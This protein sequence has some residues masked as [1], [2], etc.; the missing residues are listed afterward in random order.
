MSEMTRTF[1]AG[2][3]TASVA[4]RTFPASIVCRV[5]PSTTSG[6]A[7]QDHVYT[8]S[9]TTMRWHAGNPVATY[10]SET[11][12]P[13]WV[14]SCLENDTSEVDAMGAIT[15]PWN[16]WEVSGVAGAKVFA[17]DAAA[18][19]LYMFSQTVDAAEFLRMLARVV[20]WM[21]DF[22]N[23]FQLRDFTLQDIFYT[24]DARGTFTHHLPFASGVDAPRHVKP[25]TSPT[26]APGSA[27]HGTLEWTIAACIFESQNVPVPEMRKALWT[28]LGTN[29]EALWASARVELGKSQMNPGLRALALRFADAA[30][31]NE[32]I[33]VAAAL[34]ARAASVRSS[35]RLLMSADG[36]VGAVLGYI[37][38]TNRNVRVHE[39][40]RDPGTHR[41]ISS[42]TKSD[43]LEH[44]REVDS[45]EQYYVGVKGAKR[46]YDDILRTPPIWTDLDVM[47]AMVQ[48]W[49]AT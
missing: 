10:V 2:Q 15:L 13:I 25:F 19:D 22:E 48:S 11:N 47:D 27:S 7:P 8:L 21:R 5:S 39:A 41:L 49:G 45:V 38:I 37:N 16:E 3:G 14:K 24:V 33:D 46:A 6:A 1:T 43:A 30:R 35:A 12:A 31:A 36:T 18:G 32:R 20:R 23:T 40:Y 17:A 34:D 28:E 9:R 42:E 4:N 44:S 26:F 29:A